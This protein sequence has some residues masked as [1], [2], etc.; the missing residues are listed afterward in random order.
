MLNIQLFIEGQEVD[1]FQ[2]E[3]ITLT[4]TIQD[5]KDIEKV[6]TDYSRTFNVP[7][8]KINNKI[9][10]H[11]Y[12]YHIIGFDARKKKEA[13]LYL[14]YKLFR[15][16]KIKLDG[17]TR[18]DNKA[19]TYKLTFFGNGVNL[20][21]L[22]GDDKLDAL[23]LLKESFNFTYNDANIKTYMQTGL[24]VVTPTETF[25]D[26]IIFPL[27]THTKRL[28][29][30]STIGSAYVNTAT[31][32]NIAYEAGSAHG[33]QLSQLKPAL[34]IYPI[35]KAIEAQYNLTFSNEFFNKTNAEFYNLYLWLHNKTGGLFEDEGNV[36]PVGDF[37]LVR[38]VG[39]TIDLY[40]NYF[41]TPQADQIG[42]KKVGKEKRL[43][44]TIKPSVAEE[45]SFI[46]YKNGEVF[47]RFDIIT[48]NNI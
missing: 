1:L 27:L 34:R 35:I 30:D 20:K 41:T 4:Q 6:F 48:T 23:A 16:G 15:K 28:V 45:F 47:E 3:S 25:E 21:D 24:D 39:A 32:N 18:K 2:D 42:G 29:Y 9:F 8:S 14:N 33:L 43:D 37:E 7:A 10:Q 46:I 19:H 5:V 44:V 22:L 12:N 11:F 17:A 36:T 13:E 40:T 31:Q 26:A 38:V